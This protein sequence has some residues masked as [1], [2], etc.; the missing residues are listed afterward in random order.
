[1]RI[2]ILLYGYFYI[3]NTISL[4]RSSKNTLKDYF[5]PRDAY[6]HFI[7]HVY[8]PL[9]EQNNEIDI[10]MI[11][12]EFV[13]ENLKNLKGEL[14][15]ICNNIKIIF[16]NNHESPRMPHTVFNLL[17][18]IKM[19]GKN[20][21][22][23]YIIT[24]GDLFYKSKI[25]N[26]VPPKFDGEYCWYLF[27]DHIDLWEKHRKICDVFF[28]IDN[29]NCFDKF[30]KI[31][32]TQIMNRDLHN[33][34]KLLY[35]EINGNIKS[36]FNGNYSSDT[37]GPHKEN[38]NPIFIMINRPYYNIDPMAIFQINSDNEKVNDIIRDSETSII[39]NNVSAPIQRKVIITPKKILNKPV[40]ANLN[41][42]QYKRMLNLKKN[43]KPNK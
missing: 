10:Y 8:N 23:R 41:I 37:A 25:T 27:N 7:T 26:W 13:H 36:I 31:V 15:R 22:D 20:N 6:P 38:F 12:H 40:P 4:N 30:I 42:L 16:T 35:Q 21:Y 24:R 3:D 19:S 11:T 43:I 17:S 39:N 32:K 29:Q 2:A 14:L 18:Y 34:Y 33:V 28:V 5:F 9:K 1:M